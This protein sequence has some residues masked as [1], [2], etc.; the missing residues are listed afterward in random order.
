MTGSIIIIIII[1]EPE[2]SYCLVPVIIGDWPIDNKFVGPSEITL[3]LAKCDFWRNVHSRICRSIERHF[4]RSI[5][6]LIVTRLDMVL[7]P[8]TMI[9]YWD[10][11][12]DSAHQTKKQIP[13]IEFVR[14]MYTM[15][16]WAKN[17]RINVKN[18]TQ[19]CL[20]NM[21]ICIVACNDIT[22]PITQDLVRIRRPNLHNNDNSQ[23]YTMYYF[24]PLASFTI[25]LG[26]R[27]SLILNKMLSEWLICI[28]FLIT[29]DTICLGQKA[30]RGFGAKI[31]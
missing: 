3:R 7:D 13:I 14:Y 2:V 15:V 19:N 8:C 22:E 27:T 4:K 25:C 29:S 23:I 5:E 16:T 9:F 26:Q 18:T 24:V 20:D 6:T 12:G 10:I 31:M 28:F 1:T 21:C 11:R 17:K 30:S